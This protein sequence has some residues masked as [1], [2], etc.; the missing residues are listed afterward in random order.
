MIPLQLTLKNF[1]SYCEATLDFRGLHTACICG[2]NGA[3]KSSLLE[4]ITWTIWGQSRA[5]SED[6]VIHAGANYVRVDF[7]FMSNNQTYRVIRSRQRGRSS[8]LEFQIESSG[9]F[10][11]LTGKGLR[12]TQEQIIATLKLDYETFINS[13]YLRQ[14]RADEFMMRRP[15]ERKQIL[16][17]LLKLNHYEELA[18]QAKDLSKQFKIQAEQL[19]LSLA[20]IQQQ[21]E[22]KEAIAFQLKS[23]TGEIKQFRFVQENDREK[24]QQLKLGEHQ[25]QAWQQHFSLQKTQYQT[26]IQDCDR[27]VKEQSI[28]NAQLIELQNLLNQESEIST[29]YHH[30]LHLQQE[31]ENL[32]A[33]FQF[34]QDSQQQKQ[35]LEQQLIQ[36][37]NDLNLQMQQ[38]QTRLESLEQQEQEIQQ[39]LSRSSE[40]KVGLEELR[41]Q[42]QRLKKLDQLQQQVTPLL[43]RRYTLQTEIER[44]QARLSAKLEQLRLSEEQL[45]SQMSQV[46]QIRQAAL[47]VD[48]QIKALEKKSVYQKRVEEK[49]LER[50]S[51]QE[52]L[53]EN[54]RI[55]NEQLE[56]LHQK[57]EVLETPNS[58]CPLCEQ[59]LNEHYRHRVVNKTQTE[60]KEIQEQIW[61]IQEQVAVCNRELQVLRTEYQQLNNELKFYD[62]LQQKL[63]QL[64]A[65]LEASG[66]THAKLR[67]IQ[68][69]IEETEQVLASG[70][71]AQEL[72]SE[73]QLLNQELQ[74]LNYDE[75]THA[76]VRGEVERLRWAEIK[77]A[78]IEDA[79]RRQS[80]INAEK[81]KLLQDIL[82]LQSG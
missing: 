31:E 77:Q 45:T 26:L 60:Q 71:Y 47:S 17:D 33:K 35:Q 75:Q 68:S 27:F 54:Q 25:R 15:N 21:L 24:L 2:A 38:T 18:N 80:A 70:H 20:P 46:P 40:V 48:S 79:T 11:S 32:A 36:Q 29:G 12:A 9:S 43:Q 52:R 16:A 51:F 6:D 58:V 82:K 59:E 5:T 49:G 10:R 67:Q 23:L 78:K 8:S 4:A 64:E 3:G 19:E 81:P 55:S 74:R 30:L 39:V 69:D 28:F 62:S 57:L 22:Q 73:L 14:G 50:K 13:A 63:G 37:V 41:L 72:Q 7:Q 66:E 56:K 76:L 1:L 42:R 53:Q 44:V 61:L 65:Q 34:Y